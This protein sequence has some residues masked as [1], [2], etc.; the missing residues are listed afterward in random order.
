MWIGAENTVKEDENLQAA[1]ALRT[2]A[3]LEKNS[4][5]LQTA[6]VSK[7]DGNKNPES[8]NSEGSDMRS[9]PNNKLEHERATGQGWT[10]KVSLL[11]LNCLS[12]AENSLKFHLSNIKVPSR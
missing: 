6:S 11:S 2:F 8:A 3:D 10:G 7:E 12:S 5:L 9:S 4:T 1:S